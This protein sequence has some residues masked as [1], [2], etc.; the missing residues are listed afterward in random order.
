MI[1]GSMSNMV[2]FRL[3]M[4]SRG[5]DPIVC[6]PSC[7]FNWWHGCALTSYD[8]NVWSHVFEFNARV[9]ERSLRQCLIGLLTRYLYISSCSFMNDIVSYDIVHLFGFHMT[10]TV[11]HIHI[12]IRDI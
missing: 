3:G 2:H 10:E 8:N 6:D 7:T 4:H 9:V 5:L 1:A 12:D 11:K